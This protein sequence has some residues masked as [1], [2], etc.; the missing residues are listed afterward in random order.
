MLLL[1]TV[2]I[3]ATS[4]NLYAEDSKVSLNVEHSKRLITDFKYCR[5]SL[6]KSISEIL[7][8]DS[9]VEGEQV[10]IA[11]LLEQNLACNAN[12]NIKKTQ[13]EEWKS[14]Y[15][16]CGEALGECNSL[17]WWKI[18]FKSCSLVLL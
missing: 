14:E 13:A 15:T 5:S 3:F 4:F 8:L 11:N 17:P 9:I 6:K 18:D 12:Y 2:I 1:I 10:K 16:K 7:I